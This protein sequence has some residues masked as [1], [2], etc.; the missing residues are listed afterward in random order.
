MFQCRRMPWRGSGSGWVSGYPIEAW[1]GDGIGV[2]GGE[3]G[4]I[5]GYMLLW[6]SFDVLKASTLQGYIDLSAPRLCFMK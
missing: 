1:G 3:T 5:G 6:V 4:L 2:S